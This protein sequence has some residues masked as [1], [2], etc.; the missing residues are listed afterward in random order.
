MVLIQLLLPTTGTDDHSAMTALAETRRELVEQFKGVTAYVRSPAKGRRRSTPAGVLAE[1][2]RKMA[3]PG[4]AQ[5]A[6]D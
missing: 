6:K 1:Q 4:S 5:K 2:H 3:E